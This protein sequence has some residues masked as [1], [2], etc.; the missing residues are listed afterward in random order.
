MTLIEGDGIGPEIS[1]SVKDIFAAAKVCHPACSKEQLTEYV[2][3]RSNGSR[4]TS[5][6]SSRMAALPSPM[7]RSK[8]CNEITSPS[9]ALLRYASDYAIPPSAEC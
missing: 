3:S 9:R 1:Q 5:L 6:Q 7:K 2:R 8:V 4:S